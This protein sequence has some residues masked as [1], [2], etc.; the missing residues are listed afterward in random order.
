MPRD[1][2][3][4]VDVAERAGVSQAAVSR[5]YTPGGSVSEAMRAKV[6]KVAAEMGYRPNV[7]AR[8]LIT[9]RSRIIG[10]VV[11]E[12]NNLYY[13]MALQRI[14]FALRAKGY[15]LMVFVPPSGK[16]ELNEVIDE[17]LNYRVAGIL[18]LSV[19]MPDQIAE[20][21]R[22]AGIPV[23][24]FNRTQLDSLSSQVVSDNV[25]G[26]AEIARYLVAGGHQRIAQITGRLDVSSGAD[27]DAGFRAGLLDAG[28][29][30]M[31][32][33]SGNFTQEG[34]IAAVHSLFEQP[35]VPDALY[36]AND[37]MAFS[38]LDALRNDLGLRVPQ[39]V[40]VVGYD[41]VDAAAWP[42]YDLTTYQ[43]PIDRMV[44]VAVS[45]L[46]AQDSTDEA[47]PESVVLPGKLIERGSA[48]RP[49]TWG[50]RKS[51]TP[52]F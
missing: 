18:A 24:M 39:D 7:L 43:Q 47:P 10:L 30:L 33:A 26:S 13:P 28:S 36:V 45:M 29:D 35:V 16:S 44:D 22:D 25:G 41:G 40:S 9:G 52:P 34:A 37:L 2:V 42:A 50:G 20:S 32:T 17:F 15:N 48:R 6:L 38:V 1:K 14:S 21:C 4:S 12:M 23:V 31:A 11:R 5:V 51:G 8:S 49:A 46:L 27:R 19:E 3:T